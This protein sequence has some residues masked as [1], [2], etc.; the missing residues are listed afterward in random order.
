MSRLTEKGILHREP[1]ATHRHAAY[2]YTA[3]L[4]RLDVLL[5]RVEQVLAEADEV[6]RQY[7]AAEI[8]RGRRAI[9]A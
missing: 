6:E 3:M 8:R 9:R 2:R 4:R 7:V 5:A 1:I